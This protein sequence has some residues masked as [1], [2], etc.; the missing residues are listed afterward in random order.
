MKTLIAL[1]L[2]GS[3]AFAGGKL[4]L[5]NNMYNDGKDYRPQ[6]G[7]GIYQPVFGMAFN[8]WTGYGEQPLEA[9]RDSNWFTTKNQVDLFVG[10]MTISPGVQYIKAMSYDDQRT[11]AYLKLDYQLW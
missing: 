2:I 5:Q 6:I 10:R 7:F 8:S 3:S 9:K 11:Y 4:S 1:L